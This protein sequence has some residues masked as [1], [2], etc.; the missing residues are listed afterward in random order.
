MSRDG[1][2]TKADKVNDFQMDIIFKMITTSITEVDKINMSSI[3]KNEIL[4]LN[5]RSAHFLLL[6]FISYVYISFKN[7]RVHWLLI[8]VDHPHKQVHILDPLSDSKKHDCRVAL[9]RDLVRIIWPIHFSFYL[10]KKGEWKIYTFW[11]AAAPV[12]WV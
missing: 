6:C 5:I 11:F 2:R 9:V 7:R 10:Y 12:C 1:C 8:V 4:S 3:N